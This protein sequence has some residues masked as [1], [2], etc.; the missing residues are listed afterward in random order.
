ML[1]L[2]LAASQP[3]NAKD[4]ITRISEL[5]ENRSHDN[6]VS[7]FETRQKKKSTSQKYARD[8][9]FIKN[10][11]GLKKYTIQDSEGKTIAENSFT[12][13]YINV[14][15]LPSGKYSVSVT[16]PNETRTFRFTK[17]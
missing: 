11:P 15:G 10:M 13:S 5:S 8:L 17:K 9:I 7:T 4:R 6:N 2:C 14:R 3:A 12:K 1:V 16:N